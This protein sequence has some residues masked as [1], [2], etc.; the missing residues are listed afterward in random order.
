MKADKLLT[1]IK[2]HQISVGDTYTLSAD[3]GKLKKGEKVKVTKK[4]PDGNDIKLYL[5]N[6]KGV[7]DVFYLD[8]SDDFEELT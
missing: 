5:T 6:E 7:T 8:Q 3:L 1:E 2:N 4:R